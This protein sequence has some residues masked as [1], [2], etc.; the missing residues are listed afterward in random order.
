[1]YTAL[2]LR[3]YLVPPP[4]GELASYWFLALGYF[5]LVLPAFLPTSRDAVW[6]RAKSVGTQTQL[7]LRS[8]FLLPR[9]KI[10]STQRGAHAR[11]LDASSVGVPPSNALDSL[12]P[13][14]PAPS[15]ALMGLSLVGN[16]D[17][18]YDPVKGGY[19]DA[20]ELQTVTTASRLKPGG[21]L[22]LAHS[23]GGK[24]WVHLCYDS[25]GFSQGRME[26][27]WEELGKV[28]REY[29]VEGDD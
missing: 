9:V 23:F 18:V 6:L 3:P 19:E 4:G 5:N 27:F 12:A 2:S 14:K 8:R 17:K 25:N 7:V 16:L 20:I 22:L 11:G 1:M 21:L 15:A 28:V 26:A 24:L 10:A 29:L 13:R